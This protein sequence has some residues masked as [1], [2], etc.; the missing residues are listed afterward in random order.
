MHADHVLDLVMLAGELARSMLAEGRLSLYV[1]GGEGPA[2]LA[3]LDAAFAREPGRP[4]RFDSA[5]EVREYDASD[6]ISIGALGFT[7]ALTEHPPPCYA[8]RVTDG[9]TAIVYGADGRAG[10]GLLR[11]AA[12]A[13]LLV[14]EA[15][16]VDDVAAAAAHGHMTAT[17]AGEVAARAQASRLLLTH[18][19]AGV[20][21]GALGE[22]AAAAFAGPVDVAHEGY[23]YDGP[24]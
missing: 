3:R 6:S 16:Y 9:T 10:E 8:A 7:F 13:D 2:A 1:P 20:P 18:T 23:V 17:Q 12:R 4:T 21:P 14:L 11:L 15:T 19:I 22:R 24:A 5:F